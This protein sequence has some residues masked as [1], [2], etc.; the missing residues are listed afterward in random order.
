MNKY[1]IGFLLLLWVLGGMWLSRKYFCGTSTP[2]AIIPAAVEDHCEG[3]WKINDGSAFSLKAPTNISF[4][5][6]SYEPTKLS[7]GLINLIAKTSEYLKSHR[8]RHISIKGYYDQDEVN[9]SI[10]PNLGLARANSIKRMLVDNGVNS[11]QVDLTSALSVDKCWS[12]IDVK[13]SNGTVTQVNRLNQ[14]IDFKFD[15]AVKNDDKLAAIK[16]RL[17]GNPIV[18]HFATDKDEVGLTAQQRKDFAD[19]I[20]YLDRVKDARL[21]IDGHTDNVG[22]HSYNINLSKER[23]EFARKYITSRGGIRIAK[24]DVAG[25]GPDKP[26]ASNRTEEGKAQNRRVEVTLK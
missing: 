6:S 24:M 3:E 13:N 22:D 19:L 4:N 26:V 9:K 23:A 20:Y 14:G 1:L 21:D 15:K 25:Y 7:G 5:R 2:A 12:K 17:K 18:L 10:L 8:D 11:S 16:S